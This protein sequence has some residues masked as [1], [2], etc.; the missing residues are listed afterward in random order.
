MLLWARKLVHDVGVHGAC[1]AE[2]D[3]CAALLCLYLNEVLPKEE[4]H[5]QPVNLVSGQHVEMQLAE[6]GTYLSKRLWVREIRKF[7]THG[8]QKAILITDYRSDPTPLAA[9][10]SAR[11]SQ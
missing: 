8:H 1:P 10:M 3:R 6:R 4:F 2:I 9:G 7:T 5:P 11:W